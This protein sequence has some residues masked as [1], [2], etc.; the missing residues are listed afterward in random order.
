MR[1][2]SPAPSEDLL[3][4]AP[5]PEEGYSTLDAGRSRCAP[6]APARWGRRRGSLSAPGVMVAAGPSAPWR[7]S[8]L[9]S[10][11][12]GGPWPISVNLNIAPGTRIGYFVVMNDLPGAIWNRDWRVLRQLLPP[13]WEAEAKK[14]GAL[15][16]ARGV[17]SAE[18]LLRVLL[19]HLAAG[20]SLVETAARA[21]SAGLARLSS[22]ALFK[23]LQAAEDWLRWL[24]V[25]E[26]RLLSGPMPDGDRRIL[27]VDATTVS[28]PGSTGT[29]WRLHYG[30]NLVNLQ[31]E[32]FELTDVRGGESLRRLPVVRGDVVLGD[33]GYSQAPGIQHVLHAGA[34]VVVRLNWHS[35]PLFSETGV[36]I[37]PLA[38]RRQRVGEVYE[39][40]CWVHPGAGPPF[41]GR[42]IRVRRS[43]AATQRAQQR[44]RRRAKRKGHRLRPETL[45]AASYFL[46]WTSLPPATAAADILEL[47]RR[48]WQIEL[49]FKRMKTI[50][51]LGHLPKKDPASARAWLHGKLLTSLLVE[52]TIQAANA[53]SPWG[54]ALPAPLPLA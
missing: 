38:P 18:A 53:F 29:D 45:V 1:I 13:G 26:R 17:E 43:A 16:R 34:D 54:Y 42:L 6:S 35:L 30:I 15:R 7:A 36:R 4:A 10:R 52:R 3:G 25:E 23:R 32:Y 24:A 50:L 11:R 40:A 9:C 5:L 41:A 27:A 39:R 28:E 44:L 14:R 51:G 20:C 19:I 48:R 21:R 22:V 46:L 31:C 47:Y 37:D 33:G 49:N 12:L 2:T 8:R